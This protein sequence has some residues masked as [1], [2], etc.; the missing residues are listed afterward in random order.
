MQ[1]LIGYIV[2]SPFIGFLIL[3]LLGKYLSKT[4]VALIG[5]GAAGIS[6]LLTIVVGTGYLDHPDS[7]MR[8]E[9]W[10]WFQVGELDPWITFLLD[11]LSLIFVFVIL[12]VLFINF[13][14]YIL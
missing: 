9:L 7:V 14:L 13:V 4:A 8:I 3:V 6:A 10:Q 1:H 11:P 2:L 5:V 12:L